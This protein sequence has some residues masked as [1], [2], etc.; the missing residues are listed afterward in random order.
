MSSARPICRTSRREFLLLSAG[1]L[2]AISVGAKAESFDHQHQAFDALLR[3]HVH[4][5]PGGHASEVDYAGLQRDASLLRAYLETLSS[6]PTAT[7]ER[8]TVAERRAFLINAYNGFTLD[9]VLTKYP[10]LES[11]KD[12]G[13]LFSSPWK[14][15]FFALLGEERHLDEIEHGLLR[16]SSDFDDPRI[17]F[18]VNCAS[19]G[20][21]ALRPEAFAAERLDAQLEDQTRRFLGDRS[22]NRVDAEQS[23]LVLSPIF[24]WY[25]SDFSRGLR[26]VSSVGQF[27][28]GYQR[29]LGITPDQVAALHAGQWSIA[30]SDYD[31][32]LNKTR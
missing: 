12:L 14:Q 31:W 10:D 11:I 25:E 17:H 4:W 27:I 32:S 9:L 20:C 28:A 30:Y 18:A 3:K 26:G 16:G 1:A 19:I 22:R 29:V 15:R 23:R 21:P 24:D 7:F 13:G 2:I 8:W 5:L 6:V